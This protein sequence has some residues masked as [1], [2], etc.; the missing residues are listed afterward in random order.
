MLFECW[1]TLYDAGLT[2]KQQRV[3]T[4]CLLGTNGVVQLMLTFTCWQ[5]TLTMIIGYILFSRFTTMAYQLPHLQKKKKN[6]PPLH[7]HDK[8][9]Q[10]KKN[11][12]D[13][14]SLV[15][16]YL[17]ETWHIHYNDLSYAA[18]QRQKTVFV[19]YRSKQILPLPLQSNMAVGW[20]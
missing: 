11:Q 13:L 5:F 14:F 6:D 12:S 15:W 16:C 7:K 17:V 8:W 3:S 4:W 10:G 9:H 1:P 2:T 19:H 20:S 18:V